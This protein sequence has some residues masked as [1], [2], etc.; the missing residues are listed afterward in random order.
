MLPWKVND[1]ETEEH[2]LDYLAVHVASGESGF[3]GTV[4]LGSDSMLSRLPLKVGYCCFAADS[5]VEKR[6]DRQGTIYRSFESSHL[7][8]QSKEHAVL[9]CKQHVAKP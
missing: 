5:I 2:G 1:S 6:L 4:Q 8:G 9:R 7:D 3:A